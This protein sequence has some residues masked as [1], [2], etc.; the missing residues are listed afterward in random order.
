MQQTQQALSLC[1][2]YLPGTQSLGWWSV[3]IPQV[4]DPCVPQTHHTEKVL[5][6]TRVDTVPIFLRMLE[7]R[8]R[9]HQRAGRAVGSQLLGELFADTVAIREEQPLSVN[10]NPL[11]GR[12]RLPSP[13]VGVQQTIRRLLRGSSQELTAKTADLGHEPTIIVVN[14]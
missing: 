12:S 14:R 7:R 5:G 2:F 9:H 13:F 8:T 4:D 3:E 10:P 6:G 1:N 11:C